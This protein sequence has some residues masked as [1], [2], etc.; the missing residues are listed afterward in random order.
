[1]QSYEVHVIFAIKFIE[2]FLHLLKILKTIMKNVY[3]SLLLVCLLVGCKLDKDY[4][5]LSEISFAEAE[6]QK[7]QGRSSWQKPGLVINK[8][9]DISDKTVADIGAG[10]GFFSFRMALKAKKIISTDIDAN[11]IELIELQKENLPAEISQKIETRLVKPTETGL[12]KDEADIIVIV[13]TITLID[14][15]ENYLKAAKDVLIDGGKILLV[16][17]KKNVSAMSAPPADERLSTDQTADL[18]TAAGFTIEEKD[19]TTLDY[20][21]IIIASKQAG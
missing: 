3:P 9:G 19:E 16:D 5:P 11:M 13:N 12:K 2:K 21:Y 6:M 18:L 14:N 4:I 7:N 10:T 15:P 20:Q 17:F 8:L 1:M